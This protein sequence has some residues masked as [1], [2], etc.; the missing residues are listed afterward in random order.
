MARN[1]RILAKEKKNQTLIIKLFGDFDATSACELM[2]V[3]NASVKKAVNV[4]IDTDGLLTI[5]AFGL[6]VLF[7]RISVLNRCRADIK[8]TGRFSAVFQMS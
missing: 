8:V 3:L 7:P 1:F 6:D 5:N 2:H 4:A